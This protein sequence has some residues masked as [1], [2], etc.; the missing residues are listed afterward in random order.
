MTRLPIIEYKATQFT[1]DNMNSEVSVSD[2]RHMI[3]INIMYVKQITNF[4]DLVDGPLVKLPHTWAR[5][6]KTL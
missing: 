5:S 1:V 4:D 3:R 6:L 2:L